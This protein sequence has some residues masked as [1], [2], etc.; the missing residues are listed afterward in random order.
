[1]RKSINHIQSISS[2]TSPH[3]RSELDSRD[4]TLIS[5]ENNNNN[6]PRKPPIRHY[7]PSQS[8]ETYLSALLF[9]K[10]KTTNTNISKPMQIPALP[11]AIQSTNLIISTPLKSLPGIIVPNTRPTKPPHHA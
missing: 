2:T 3:S 5:N 11:D 6:K 10:T 9:A 7:I 1:M 4:K 8:P